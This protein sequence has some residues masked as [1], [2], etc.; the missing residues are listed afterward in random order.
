MDFAE[1]YREAKDDCLRT[2]LVSVGDQDT[3]QELVAVSPRSPPGRLKTPPS[4]V[5]PS[6]L[7]RSSLLRKA[8]PRPF[9]SL[10]GTRQPPGPVEGAT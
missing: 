2:V 6:L 8:A 1:F 7:R 10:A 5:A 3:A 4:L 9:G